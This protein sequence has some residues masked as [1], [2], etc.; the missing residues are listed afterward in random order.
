MK[1]DPKDSPI[2]ALKYTQSEA[3]PDTVIAHFPGD[4]SWE[5]P[6][7]LSDDVKSLMSQDPTL[8]GHN[9]NAARESEMNTE[10][11]K[12]IRDKHNNE[13]T[14]QFKEQ[15]DRPALILIH[16][17]DPETG[18]RFQVCQCNFASF[19][20]YDSVSFVKCP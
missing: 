16:A 5:I 1:K 17:K 15:K 13:M 3:K 14:I 19:K 6:G 20:Q 2:F 9:T 8:R 11:R 7:L 4:K 12:T 18:K 10:D